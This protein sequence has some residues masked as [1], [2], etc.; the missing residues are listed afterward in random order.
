MC[1]PKRSRTVWT[2][3]QVTPIFLA[4]QK[5]NVAVI[6]SLLEHG[7]NPTIKSFSWNSKES[8]TPA[9]VGVHCRACPRAQLCSLACKVLIWARTHP[10]LHASC[11]RRVTLTA[12]HVVQLATAASMR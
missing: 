2:R 6:K 7:A 3:P 1:N 10:F 5:N 11:N 9:Q 4:A 12:K 8:C